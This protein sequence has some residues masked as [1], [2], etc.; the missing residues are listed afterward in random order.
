MVRTSVTHNLGLCMV[1]E[2]VHVQFM[3][4][5]RMRFPCSPT[6][7]LPEFIAQ[8][9][10]TSFWT[11]W[12]LLHQV[13]YRALWSLSDYCVDPL[14]CACCFATISTFHTG[15]TH[16]IIVL[17]KPT[18]DKHLGRSEYNVFCLTLLCLSQHCSHTLSTG[19]HLNMTHPYI[20][21]TTILSMYYRI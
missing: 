19:S 9:D 5:V 1:L 15:H 13:S 14:V 20:E 3:L 10:L 18:L 12:H 16:F 11:V 4:W 6:V 17:V 21:S 7:K 2:S 8:V